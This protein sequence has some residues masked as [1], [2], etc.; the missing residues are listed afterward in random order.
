MPRPE[1]HLRAHVPT[2]THPVV[3]AATTASLRATSR[4]STVRGTVFKRCIQWDSTSGRAP[5]NCQRPRTHRLRNVRRTPAPSPSLEWR[6]GVK[7]RRPCPISA[8]RANAASDSQTEPEGSKKTRTHGTATRHLRPLNHL[9]FMLI[10][11]TPTKLPMFH[12]PASEPDPVANSSLEGHTMVPGPSSNNKDARR[13]RF[14][15]P[16]WSKS[17]PAR[18]PADDKVGPG[19]P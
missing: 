3:G 15:R 13:R 6:W 19:G 7:T 2:S 5:K 17:R 16:S 9:Y 18:N 10:L 14:Y 12:Y 1:Y 11:C 8:T 4:P